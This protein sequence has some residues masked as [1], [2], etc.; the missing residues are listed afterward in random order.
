VQSDLVAPFW[1]E[2][3]NESLRMK[4]SKVRS[5]GLADIQARIITGQGQGRLKYTK[6]TLDKTD[7]DSQDHLA[8]FLYMVRTVNTEDNEGVFY[9]RYWP[10]DFKDQ[11]LWTLKSWLLQQHSP[12]HWTQPSGGRALFGDKVLGRFCLEKT[13]PVRFCGD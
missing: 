4:E 9:N 5:V 6:T 11:C 1:I 8:R 2:L 12:S 10:D 7:W 13:L 3:W